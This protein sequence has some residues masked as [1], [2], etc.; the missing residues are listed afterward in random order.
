MQFKATLTNGAINER[1]Y[2]LLVKNFVVE[3]NELIFYGVISMGLT[4]TSPWSPPLSATLLGTF[5][6]LFVLN[7]ITSHFQTPA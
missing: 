4:R 1:N 7:L 3:N 2:T 6:C 5:P